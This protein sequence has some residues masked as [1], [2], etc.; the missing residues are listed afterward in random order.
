[1]QVIK[2]DTQ[3]RAN[4]RAKETLDVDSL[5]YVNYYRDSEQYRTSDNHILIIGWIS[6]MNGGQIATTAVYETSGEFGE[7]GILFIYSE[8][9]TPLDRKQ[10]ANALNKA[11]LL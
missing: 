8:G 2:M 11:N 5:S 4:E 1:M 7:K 3:K 9:W 6:Y 10:I